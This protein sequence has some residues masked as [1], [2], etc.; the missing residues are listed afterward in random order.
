M[1][2]YSNVFVNT[3]RLRNKEELRYF[4]P[5]LNV[6]SNIRHLDLSNT[7]LNQLLTELG[8]NL[9]E[10]LRTSSKEL[11]SLN[12]SHNNLDENFVKKF[13]LPQRL[14]LINFECLKCLNLSFNPNIRVSSDFFGYFKKFGALNEI[15]LSK[16]QLV[17]TNK[18][19]FNAFCACFCN[20]KDIALNNLHCQNTG[21]VSRLN[22]QTLI[23]NKNEKSTSSA[24][25]IFYLNF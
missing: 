9:S 17:D 3:L 10:L 25:G 21:W 14:D 6:S 19:H 5:I 11:E 13:S 4:H 15:I 1:N 8:L 2:A 20:G 23:S 22:M 12:I 16:T 24:Q 7:N 18:R